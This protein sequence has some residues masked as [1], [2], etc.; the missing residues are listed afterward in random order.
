MKGGATELPLQSLLKLDVDQFY[1]IEFSEFP[2]R[3][4]ETAMWMM[5]HI[6]NTQASLEF[7][8]PFLRIPLRRSPNIVQADALEVDWITIAPKN[9]SYIFGNP[10][11]VGKKQQSTVQKQGLK[12]ALEPEGFKVGSLDYVTGW[13]VKACALLKGNSK[14]SIAFVSTNSICQGE[15]VSL[16]WPGIFERYQCKIS[17]AHRTFEWGSDARGKAHVHCCII[18]LS[19]IMNKNSKVILFD[20]ATVA[21]EPNAVS[22]TDISPYLINGSSL[23]N[24]NLT[25]KKARKPLSARTPVMYGSK[26]CDNG[27]LILSADEKKA[28]LT[29][30]PDF[31]SY[32]KPLL[33]S[34]DS[35]SGDYRYCLWLTTA[36]PA[37]LKSDAS[38]MERIRKVREFRLKSTKPATRDDAKTPALFQEIRHTEGAFILIPRH[39]SSRRD[40]IP[41]SVWSGGE[42]VHDSAFMMMNWEL[43]DFA[44]LTSAMFT[45][46]QDHVGGR[47][48]SDW[49]FSSDLVYNTFPMPP[50]GELSKLKQHAQSILDVRACYPDAC[51]ADLYDPDVMP[52][53]L[54]HVHQASDRAVDRLYRKAVFK[55]ERDRVEHLLQLYEKITE[56]LL[57]KPTKKRRRR[58]AK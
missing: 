7:G 38:V 3:I 47:I 37:L 56:P 26:P 12:K 13:F 39:S 58:Q 30:R 25:V 36:P 51:L 42:V 29:A 54:R 15:Q 4:A 2:A 40:Y 52:V 35:I 55:S 6:M 41:S 43:H 20:Y 48:K 31:A 10:P 46:W 50:A 33:G 53:D 32:I 17:F 23:N 5:D 45:A 1:G 49:R 27:N 22:T 11:F 28:F 44:L 57:A 19:H 9:L 8:A 21:S 14:V 16:L 34:D 18:G 24:P